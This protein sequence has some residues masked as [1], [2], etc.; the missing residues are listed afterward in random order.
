MELKNNLKS[1]I[2]AILVF[3]LFL[4]SALWKLTSPPI[5]QW[6]EA[7][8]A[9]NAL[10]MLINNDYWTMRVDGL[11]TLYNTKPPLAIWLQATCMRL[12]GANELSVRLPSVLSLV[13]ILFILY[14]FC[15]K[16]LNVEI[17]RLSFAILLLSIGFMRVHILRSGDLDAVLSFFTTLYIF[18]FFDLILSKNTI[19]Y[20][21]IQYNTIQYA[22][23]TLGF[24]GAFFTKSV[25]C[26]L[27]LPALFLSAF[28]VRKN[29]SYLKNKTFIL[30]FFTCIFL[31]IAY[32]WHMESVVEGY[33]NK[34]YASEFQRSY[35]DLMPWFEHRWYYYFEEIGR[36]FFPFVL[37]FPLAIFTK[38]RMAKLL[39]VFTLI[40]LL[41]I[42]LPPTKLDWYLA[43]LYPVMSVCIAVLYAEILKKI[44]D[45]NR[46]MLLVGFVSL[47]ILAT[48]YPIKALYKTNSYTGV[49]AAL[50]EH[51]FFM[52]EL[53]KRQP[54]V[55][56][57]VVTMSAK[58]E[59]HY[60]QAI[61]YK[62]AY[63][64]FDGYNIR[65]TPVIANI[66]ATDTLLVCQSQKLDSLKTL[67]FT[68]VVAAS[69]RYQNCKLLV[70]PK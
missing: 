67:G 8:Y 35:K 34:V 25:A 32:Y 60:Q 11:P 54:N 65:F 10:E 63:N 62:R 44:A 17:A 29:L 7:L 49:L 18:A 4:F 9:N 56:N 66:H 51:G 3:T 64:Y 50:E 36:Q 46:K 12:F 39:V 28:V 47:S 5:Y 58:H 26:L 21:T 69:E 38:E 48:L 16:H 57:Y 23:L 19:Q 70:K 2:Y 20:N 40:F 22:W 59:E 30:A 6:D 14:R 41:F 31:I 55:K 53:K 15:K 24:I 33:F 37:L 52:C 1:S 43:P 45:S 68:E 27:P 61:F 42:S 13:G